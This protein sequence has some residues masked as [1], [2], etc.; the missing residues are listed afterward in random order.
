MVQILPISSNSNRWPNGKKAN[1]L[2][3]SIDFITSG[4]RKESISE[5]DK[6]LKLNILY[7]KIKIL[8]T[9]FI[10]HK[11]TANALYNSLLS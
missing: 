10:K 2:H 11:Y 1:T 7:Y 9:A 4:I 8:Q 3:P 5:H 6:F